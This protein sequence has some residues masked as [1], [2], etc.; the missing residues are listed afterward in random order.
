MFLTDMEK[1]R[2]KITNMQDEWLNIPQVLIFLSLKKSRFIILVKN[3]WLI[4]RTKNNCCLQQGKC[5]FWRRRYTY[6]TEYFWNSEM[7]KIFMTSEAKKQKQ[8]EI[9]SQ[10]AGRCGKSESTFCKEFAVYTCVEWT[11]VRN[12]N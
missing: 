1:C 8:K 3:F 4:A 5:V 7:A 2:P 10:C 6:I 9:V 11:C 12:I